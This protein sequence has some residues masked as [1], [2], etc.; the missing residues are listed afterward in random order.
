M[1]SS[2]FCWAAPVWVWTLTRLLSVCECACEPL[3]RGDPQ[4]T[5]TLTRTVSV[6]A[7]L[8]QRNCSFVVPAALQAEARTAG[9]P[10][11]IVGNAAHLSGLC[12]CA[13]LARRR[14]R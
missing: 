13:P 5:P 9:R 12:L 11:L 6:R 3:V 8:S 7:A 10:V 4:R 2:A 1:P 14:V